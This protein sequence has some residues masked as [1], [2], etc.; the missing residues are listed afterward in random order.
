MR[1]DWLVT[2]NG[3]AYHYLLP[4]AGIPASKGKTLC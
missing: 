2:Y 1:L 3:R 4:F